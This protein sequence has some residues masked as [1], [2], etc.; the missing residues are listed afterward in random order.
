MVK[1][2]VVLDKDTYNFPLGPVFFSSLKSIFY[3]F[4]YLRVRL[5]S[6]VD[7]TT[8]WLYLA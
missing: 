2:K 4:I 6:R 3:N 1:A 7:A 5:E 8:A